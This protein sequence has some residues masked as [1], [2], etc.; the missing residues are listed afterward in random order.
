M[1]HPLTPN[2]HNMTDADISSKIGDLNKRIV[3]GY[4]TGNS[5]LISQAQ[6]MVGDYMEEQKRRDQERYNKALE[7][8]KDKGT[9]WDSLIDI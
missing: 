4:Q 5:Q 1:N 2:L 3:F 7:S 9:D 6:M 8:S